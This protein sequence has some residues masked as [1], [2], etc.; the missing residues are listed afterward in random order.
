MFRKIIITTSCLFLLGITS[1]VMGASK[2]DGKQIVQTA[3]VLVY[4][5]PDVQSQVIGVLKE[6][7]KVTLISTEGN[8]A[9]ISRKMTGFVPKKVLG[10]ELKPVNVDIYNVL[11]KD[12]KNQELGASKKGFGESEELSAAGKGFGESEELS[13]AGKGFGESEELS[14]AGKGF[15]ESEELSA[16]GKGF[17]ESE[18]LSAAGK[19]FG[20][21]EEL[22]AAGKGFGENEEISAAGKGFS[23]KTFVNEKGEVDSISIIFSKYYSFNKSGYYKKEKGL[24][25]RIRR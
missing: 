3:F 18:E 14:A 2:T 6:G 16:A 11:T 21:S 24:L 9:K 19:G 22:S 12:E 17:G 15:G 10:T 20:E 5:K 13:A 25:N 7:E 4:E 23:Q 1:L 8:W